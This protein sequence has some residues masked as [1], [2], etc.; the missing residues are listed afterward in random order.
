[1]AKRLI[2]R[3]GDTS[4]HA[5]FTGAAAEVTVDTEK[6]TL[7]VH[8]G[9]RAGGFP[10][11][12]QGP[13]IATHTN[14]TETTYNGHKVFK[15]TPTSGT[16]V[17]TTAGLADIF[18]VAGGGGGSSDTG[19]GGQFGAPGG[20]GGAVKMYKSFW[21][22]RGTYT[23]TVGAGGSGGNPASKG[24]NTTFADSS[25]TIIECLGGGN[26]GSS[27]QTSAQCNGGNGGG[28][29][30]N[31]STASLDVT[32]I[33]GAGTQGFQGG[34]GKFV[35]GSWWSGSG[36]GGAGGPGFNGQY[37]NQMSG[38]PGVRVGGGPD[39]D[40]AYATNSEWYV[41]WYGGGANG[42]NTLTIDNPITGDGHTGAD[43]NW[44][45]DGNRGRTVVCTAGIDGRGAGGGGGNESTGSAADGADGGNGVVIIRYF[46]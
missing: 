19:Q 33:G 36:G 34:N 28:T 40:P 39:G 7:V 41:E 9:V 10:L 6:D 45:R 13:P 37:T 21:L 11:A 46:I 18:M 30:T 43:T 4:D 2:L 42:G 26:A 23:I 16:L 15:W 29:S 24:G 5:S 8:D 44:I 3:K 22:L 31:A 1:M 12:H 35:H 17:V 32:K 14:A 27:S 20:G 25:A 38:G